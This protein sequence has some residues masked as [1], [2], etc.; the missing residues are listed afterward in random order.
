MEE[1]TNHFHVVVSAQSKPEPIADAFKS[2][3]TRKLRAVG[4]IG[5]EI[6]HGH[7]ARAAAT[8]GSQSISR[9]QLIMCSMGRET[10]PI[11]TTSVHP[12]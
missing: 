5:K 10:F 9:E 1:F 4:L 3:S 2:Y 6:D 7:A 8:C 12:P 11:S